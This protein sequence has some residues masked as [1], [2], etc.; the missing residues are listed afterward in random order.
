MALG[1]RQTTAANAQHVSSP[2]TITSAER[3]Q[4]QTSIGAR[5]YSSPNTVN[6]VSN[7]VTTTAKASTAQTQARAQQNVNPITTTGKAVVTPQTQNVSP[8]SPANRA[9]VP[10]QT[11]NV[12]PVSTSSQNIAP[13]VANNNLSPSVA[14]NTPQS[15]LANDL[16][17][18]SNSAVDTAD[19]TGLLNLNQNPSSASQYNQSPTQR[20]Q[21]MMDLINGFSGGAT[22]GSLLGGGD[23]SLGKAN[24]YSAL[25][26]NMADSVPRADGKLDING[27]LEDELINTVLNNADSVRPY[28]NPNYGFTSDLGDIYN[29]SSDTDVDISSKS[30]GSSGGTRGAGGGTG[31]G[32]T[33][34]YDS[35]YDLDSLYDLL[36][37]RLNEYNNQYGSLMDSLLG[38]YN[39]NY[40][41]LEDYYNAMLNALGANYADSESL[42]NAQLGSAQQEL[43]NE[44][45][46]ALQEQYISRM[47]AE[48]QLADQLDAYGL[49]GGASESVMAG[50]LN[51]YLSNRNSV[52]EKTQASLKDLLSNYLTNM[53]NARQNYSQNLMNAAQNRLSARQQLANNLAE[54][55]ANAASYLANARSGA[56]ED[57]FNALAKQYLG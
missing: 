40:A 12:N 4:A 20:T 15:V 45:K 16:L 39:T 24:N 25:R 5:P 17:G 6:P 29:T 30:G 56:Y 21:S 26:N 8:V 49:T 36:N 47:L 18:L 10:S 33:A 57:L 50:L 53:S 37:A 27:L 52:E 31:V 28:S 14:A 19:Y 35:A 9:S 41:N 44:R 3:K 13:S 51:N 23:S 48:K 38:A 32:G 22:L 42:L 34:A 7:P 43:E 55:Q 11:Q 54:S 1:K 2:V 46:R